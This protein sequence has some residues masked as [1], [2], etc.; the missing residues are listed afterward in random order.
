[1]KQTLI[2]TLCF[3][4]TITITRAQDT[5]KDST[6][7]GFRFTMV[8]SLPATPV[9]N[10]FHTS[11]CWSFS[12]I[13]LLEAELLRLGKGEFD[14]S[15]MFIVRDV[16]ERKARK[17]VRLHGS[18]ALSGGGAFNDVSSILRDIGMV[19]DE[20]YPGLSY[21][22]DKHMHNELDAVLRAYVDALIKN[23]NGE[24]STAWFNGVKGILDAYLGTAP[25]QF[26]WNGKNYTPRS[27]ADNV[28]GLNPDDYVLLSSYTHHPF[29]TQFVLEVPDNWDFGSVYNVPLG[30]LMRTIDSAIDGGYTVAWASDVSEKG[31]NFKKGMAVIPEKDWNDMSK[32]EQDSV[33]LAPGPEKTITQELRQAGFDNYSTTD[34][35]GMHITGIA[36]DENGGTYYYVKNSWGLKNSRFDGWFYASKA[37][38]EYKTMSIMLNKNAIPSDIRRKLGL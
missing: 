11:T 7:A 6:D 22:S 19:P 12:S 18:N 29:Y 10:Q 23:D 2:L 36:T 26:A 34:D 30:E 5:D 24:L 28:M 33:F 32:G 14:L 3:L 4:F 25:T 35:H 38:V 15:E 17:Y 37:F 27:F 9:K 8:K 1:M 31:F 20:V 16:Y 13:S 21:G